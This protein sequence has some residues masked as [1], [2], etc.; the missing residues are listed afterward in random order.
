LLGIHLVK[1]DDVGNYSPMVD[2]AV[3]FARFSP[4][5]LPLGLSRYE[6]RLRCRNVKPQGTINR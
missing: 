5:G 1:I 4:L 6:S 3:L 2:T